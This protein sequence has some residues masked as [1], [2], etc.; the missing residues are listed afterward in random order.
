MLFFSCLLHRLCPPKIPKV[1]FESL[2]T[3]K[4]KY[5]PEISKSAEKHHVDIFCVSILASSPNF[6]CLVQPSG[7]ASLPNSMAKLK[8]AN[9]PQLPPPPS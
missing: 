1:A 9:K 5:C 6:R 2:F 7:L 4:L 8:Q 3:G